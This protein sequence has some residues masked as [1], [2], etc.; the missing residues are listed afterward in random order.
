VSCE[1]QEFIQIDAGV[2]ELIY[3]VDHIYK[4]PSTEPA[5]HEW[6]AGYL[7]RLLSVPGIHTAQRF[8]AVGCSPP[9]Y[10]AM[11]SIDSEDV[12]SSQAYK[13]IGGGGSQSASFHYAY[14]LWTRNLFEGAARAPVVED[15]QRVLVFDRGEPGDGTPYGAR[16]VWLRAVGLHMTTKYRAFVVLDAAEAAAASQTGGFLYEPYTAALS[17]RH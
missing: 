7:Q 13:N 9:R 16:A 6:Y 3:M 5:W 12:Y 17:A 4:E 11:Y 2:L 8:K 1:K 15:G 10:L 14:E